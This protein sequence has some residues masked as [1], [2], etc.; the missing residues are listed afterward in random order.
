MERPFDTVVKAAH[1]TL[2]KTEKN[3]IFRFNQNDK[4]LVWI[5]GFS[6]TAI[7]LIVSNTTDLNKAY[8][9]DILKTALLLLIISVI[10]GIIYR[11][12]A[13]AFLTKYQ[14]KMSFIE[15]ALPREKMM[16]TKV[17]DVSSI[18]EIQEISQLLQ[19][20]FDID[21]SDIVDEYNNTTSEESK[22]HYLEYL[23]SEYERLGEWAANDYE[24]GVN[25]LRSLYRDTFGWSDNQIDKNLEAT[26]DILSLKTYGWISTISISICIIS[27]VSVLILLAYYY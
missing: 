13:L 1:G 11:V 14:G 27:F 21:Y 23:K 12:A 4:I 18:D 8:R 24:N 7:T 2:E 6:I 5:V 16:P 10:S 26:N 15:G 25:Y 17:P 19:I 3:Y 22:E 9:S 20:Y